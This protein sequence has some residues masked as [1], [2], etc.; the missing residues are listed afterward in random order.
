MNRTEMRARTNDAR[1]FIWTM[2]DTANDTIAA[3]SR[4]NSNAE[5]RE[6]FYAHARILRDTAN[7]AITAMTAMDD[8][9]LAL[10]LCRTLRAL[11]IHTDLHTDAELPKF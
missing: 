5:L 11:L 3:L 8:P 9:V 1:R 2:I 4:P 6:I 7:N 10:I